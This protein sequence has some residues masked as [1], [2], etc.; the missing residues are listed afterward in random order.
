MNKPQVGDRVRITT[1]GEV[2]DLDFND[3]VILTTHHGFYPDTEGV[4]SIEVVTRIPNISEVT[5]AIQELK[6]QRRLIKKAWTHDPTLY[7]SWVAAVIPS[8]IALL[9]DAEDV[10]PGLSHPVDIS[11]WDIHVALAKS[12]LGKP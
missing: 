6:L 11:V 7:R 1:E 5:E 9:E 8:L 3:G 10:L 4:V 2:M 12:I